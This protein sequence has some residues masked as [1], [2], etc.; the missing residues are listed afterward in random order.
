VHG[1]ITVKRLNIAAKYIATVA[2]LSMFQIMTLAN[3]TQFQQ[4]RMRMRIALTFTTPMY[5][6]MYIATCMLYALIDR[7]SWGRGYSSSRVDF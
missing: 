1:S 7:D 3:G 2:W 5:M 6:Y 4:L